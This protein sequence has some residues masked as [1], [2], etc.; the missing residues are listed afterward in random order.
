MKKILSTILILIASM[1]IN[2]QNKANP[3]NIDGKDI[4]VL[5]INT[6]KSTPAGNLNLT[7]EQIKESS[8]F[9]DR[10]RFILENAPT[11]DYD[12]ITTR[13]GNS[14]QFIKYQNKEEVNSANIPRYSNKEVYFLAKP[15]KE[16]TVIDS[17][18]AT[19]DEV[20]SSFYN[21]ANKLVKDGNKKKFDAI[22][23]GKDKIEYIK[24]K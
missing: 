5:L 24:Y 11:K 15:V 6:N 10:I 12:A 2:A 1:A 23:V 16:F 19:N 18:L 22:I 7:K 20:N 4:Y 21:M 8:N 9:E 17:R 13:G 3:T 14:I